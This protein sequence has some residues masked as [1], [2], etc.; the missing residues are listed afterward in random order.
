MRQAGRYMPEYRQ[1]RAKV[2]FL[3]LCKTPELAAQVTVMAVERLGV[4]AA[5]IFSDI[6]PILEPMGMALEFSAGD[7][8]ELHNPIR[9]AADVER[10]SDVDAA[11]ALA[12][13]MQAITLARAHLPAHIPLIGFAGAPFTLASYMIE[14]GGS[15]HY[16]HTKTFMYTA[17]QAW[18]R[19]MALLS[20]NLVRYL[21]SQIA[22]GAQAVQLFDSWVGH[23]SPADYRTFVLP[24]SQFVI[25]HLTPGTPVLHF[26]TDTSTLLEL[27]QE[28]G[29]DVI[30]V[31][32]RIELA[33]AWQ[34]LGA[35]GIQGNLD[36]VILYAE[37]A[38]LR[39]RVQD[40]LQQA[41]N[42]PG[43][44][45]NLGHGI[46]PT[47]PVDNVRALVDMVHELSAAHRT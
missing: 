13:V 10:L 3:E 28:A 39:Q 6:L 14:G 21:N 30:G 24:Y 20:R 40:I 37:R 29:G 12:F 8:P 23:L 44:I 15:R 34:R 46:L 18:H 2:S 19:L 35:V 32:F 36:P 1:L 31:D 26:G 41:G 45:F 25:T 38:Y 33:A 27:M 42:R 17:P 7:G 47:T 4:D 9:T 16:V 22:A 43:H 5:I 11:D